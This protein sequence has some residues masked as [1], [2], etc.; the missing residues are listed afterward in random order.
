MSNEHLSFSQENDL[1]TSSSM[2]DNEDMISG[3]SEEDD[4]ENIVSI[5]CLLTTNTSI[6]MYV[7]IH[8]V[9]ILYIH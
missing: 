8:T 1:C 6:C 4:D 9:L 3:S 7:C 2:D 5:A